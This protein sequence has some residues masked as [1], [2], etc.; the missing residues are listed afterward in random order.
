M[1]KSE[2]SRLPR[3]RHWLR[4]R[5]LVDGGPLALDQGRAW[6]KTLGAEV[7]I[8]RSRARDL[9]RLVVVEAGHAHIGWRARRTRSPLL[10]ARAATDAGRIVAAVDPDH[11]NDSLLSLVAKRS[12]EVTL[13]FSI[14]AGL[15]EAEWMAG[16]GGSGYDFVPDDVAARRANAER[17]L[18]ELLADYSL[19]GDV[20]VGQTR[21][22][23]FILDV[24]AELEPS[25]IALDAPRHRYLFRHTTAD[26]VAARASQSVLVVPSISG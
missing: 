1:T 22:A 8:G 18:N 3:D 23:A 14:E 24:A 19:R 11:P 5:V 12:C 9:A 26:Q 7:V 2:A 4:E 17:R 6:A 20:R 10:V 15:R 16:F 13:L 25:L 21:P